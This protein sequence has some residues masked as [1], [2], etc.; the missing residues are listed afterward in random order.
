MSHLKNLK[1]S[2]YLMIV[3]CHLN[4]LLWCRSWKMWR[5]GG[6]STTGNNKLYVSE[7]HTDFAKLSSSQTNKCKILLFFCHNSTAFLRFFCSIPGVRLLWLS[8]RLCCSLHCSSITCWC[9]GFTLPILP[10][11]A[12][13]LCP[14]ASPAPTPASKPMP[15]NTYRT[16]A[17]VVLV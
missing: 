12:A 9:P 1:I 14:S 13:L 10:L 5:G 8:W 3:F 16:V 2:K 11:A 15:A 6:K 4:I 7:T 17:G